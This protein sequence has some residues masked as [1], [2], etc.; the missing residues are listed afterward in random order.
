MIQQ[1]HDRRGSQQQFGELRVIGHIL[2]LRPLSQTQEGRVTGQPR[3]AQ[4]VLVN[5]ARQVG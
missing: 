4:G 2:E 1:G 5:Q 3:F